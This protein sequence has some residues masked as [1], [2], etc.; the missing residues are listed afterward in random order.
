MT[1]CAASP[2]ESFLHRNST[3]I[4]QVRRES[5][6]VPVDGEFERGGSGQL[7]CGREAKCAFLKLA[8]A[9]Q[10]CSLEF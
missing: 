2:E 3:A 5:P 8:V 4:A 10:G 1:N 7:D 6:S 9:N